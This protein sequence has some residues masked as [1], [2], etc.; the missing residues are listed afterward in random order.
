MTDYE[1]LHEC[2]NCGSSD[3]EEDTDGYGFVWRV[4]RTCGWQWDDSTPP[5]NDETL[6]TE[7]LL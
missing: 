1:D 7:R 2:P 6:Y 3:T 5:E 4:C